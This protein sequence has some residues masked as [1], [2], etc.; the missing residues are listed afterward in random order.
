MIDSLNQEM[1]VHEIIW[2]NKYLEKNQSNTLNTKS[3]DPKRKSDSHRLLATT[4][5]LYQ[6]STPREAMK[7]HQKGPNISSEGFYTPGH[8]PRYTTSS[9]NSPDL[10]AFELWNTS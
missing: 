8:Q 4:Q 9:S 5:I 10:D 2:S 6:L 3:I 7:K 1:P